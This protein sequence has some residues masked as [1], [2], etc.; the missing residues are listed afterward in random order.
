MLFMNANAQKVFSVEYSNQAD[1]KVF[2]V[3]YA[4]QADLH[5][6]KVGYAN[7]T[8]KNDGKW[9]CRVCQSS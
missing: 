9:F 3:D 4:N 8:G 7:Q 6:Y 2:V 5:V 1:V